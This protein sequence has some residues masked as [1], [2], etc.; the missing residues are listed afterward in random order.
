MKW[1]KVIIDGKETS[2]YLVSECGGI[3]SSKSDL[4]LRQRLHTGG[5]K[6]V[7]MSFGKPKDA[8]V[9]RLVAEAFIPN[10][11]NKPCVNH[12]DG[13]KHNNHVSNLEWVTDSENQ[14]HSYSIGLN[15]RNGENNGLSK[16][17]EQE[18]LSIR[19]LRSTMT[20]VAL[21]KMFNV[22]EGTIREICKRRSWV[23]I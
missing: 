1:R 23:H 22:S 5:Y 14:K 13:N 16:L 15:S 17:N 12:I 10:P 8:Y 3:Y 7:T 9:H 21:S 6:Q 19:A 18:V 2:K 4:N 20:G 11:D